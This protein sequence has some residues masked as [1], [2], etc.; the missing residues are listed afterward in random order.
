MNSRLTTDFS[1]N[2]AAG[3]FHH[4]LVPVFSSGGRDKVA[5]YGSQQGPK[6]H[7]IVT[8]TVSR[9]AGVEKETVVGE[10]EGNVKLELALSF[11]SSSLV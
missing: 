2:L 4:F 9:H 6:R 10:R 11:S 3:F 7:R 1:M 8:P 5:P